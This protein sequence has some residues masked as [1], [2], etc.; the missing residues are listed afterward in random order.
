MEYKN[1]KINLFP[2]S[3]HFDQGLKSLKIQIGIW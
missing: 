3:G 2:V 1:N